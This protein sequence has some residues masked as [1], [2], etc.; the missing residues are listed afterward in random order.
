MGNAST[1][2]SQAGHSKSIY[3]TGPSDLP[4]IYMESCLRVSGAQRAFAEMF[5][6]LNAILK[7]TLKRTTTE[8]ALLWQELEMVENY[9]AIEQVC[10]AD[11]LRIETNVESGAL[12]SLVPRFLSFGLCS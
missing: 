9:L 1:G 8:K 6:R 11:H 7:S 12:E 10:F 5:T 4:V 2:I 3:S